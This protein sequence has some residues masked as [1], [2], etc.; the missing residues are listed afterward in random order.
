MLKALREHGCG[1]HAVA[2]ITGGG[3]TENLNRA[4]PENLDAQV[5]VGTW[6]MPAIIPF[7]CN[8]AHLTEAEALK[9]FNMGVG[10]V[11]IVKPEA[12]DAVAATLQAEGEK[13]FNIG[14]IIPGAGE[15]VYT[16]EDALFPA[17]FSCE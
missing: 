4:L 3:I 6:D 7:V 2:H 17:G 14:T 16:N 13:V 10:M 8:A 9:T 15:V 1:I 5:N 12:A 11:L